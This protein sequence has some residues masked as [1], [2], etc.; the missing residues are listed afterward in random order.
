MHKKRTEGR[1]DEISESVNVPP[2]VSATTA[3]VK[4]VSGSGGGGGA[5]SGGD[6]SGSD[7]PKNKANAFHRRSPSFGSDKDQNPLFEYFGWVYHLGV[8]SIGHEYCHLRFLFIKGK[9]MEMYRRDPHENP[10]IVSS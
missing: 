8:N 7:T 4:R 6:G 9:Y 5:S 2:T 10:G 3:P 1:G